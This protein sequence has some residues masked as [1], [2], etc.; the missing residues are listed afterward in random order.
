MGAK[1]A[2][3][4][5]S[6]AGVLQQVVMIVNPIAGRKKPA[7]LI[8]A[9]ERRLVKLGVS[10]E[11]FETTG[12]GDAKRIASEV[13]NWTD[14]VI[15]F[16]GDGTCREV[17]KGLIGRKVPMLPV[18]TGTES[19]F[20]REVGVKPSTRRIVRVVTSG[21]SR[22]CDV[23]WVNDDHLF[24]V[25]AGIGFD[26]E[27]AKLVAQRRVKHQ[28]V[29]HYLAP[30]LQTLVSYKFPVIRVFD[31]KLKKSE[32][33]GIVLVGNIARYALRLRVVRDAVWDD[34]KLDAIIFPCANAKELLRHAF[35]TVLR[36]HVNRSGVVYFQSRQILVES[37]EP[38]G[39]HVEGECIE[40]DKYEIKIESASLH[41]LVG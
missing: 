17:A 35:W 30:L 6:G 26:A 9:V 37:D 34:G 21:Q 19:I 13:P 31:R 12:A 15:V 28:S 3:C 24:L 23:G 5:S 22:S 16:G 38:I 20:A 32:G 18:A 7:R 33:R 40:N 8:Q 11:I 25:V 1:R 41:I 2:N 29:F 39:A 27:V 10:V 14:A 4:K 36:R